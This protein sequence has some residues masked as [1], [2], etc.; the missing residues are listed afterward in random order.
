MGNKL[1]IGVLFGGA[2]SEYEI[3]LLS[4]TSV[5]QNI[6]FNKYDIYK[7]GI[8]RKGEMFLFDGNVD[9][10]MNDTWEENNCTPCTISSNCAYNGIILLNDNI[11]IIRIDCYFPVLHGKNGEDGTIQGLFELTNTPFVGCDMLSSASCMDKDVTKSLL[12]Q[13]NIKNSKWICIHS[14]NYN[15]NSIKQ[16]V[17]TTI[18]YPCFVKPANAGS[19]IGISKV[20]DETSLDAAILLAFKHDKKVLIEENINGIEIECAVLGNENPITSM[21]GEI[22]PCND[23]YDYDAKYLA[24]KTQTFAPARLSDNVTQ[25]IQRIAVDAYKKLGCS[26]FSRIDF[27]YCSNGDIILNEINTIPG[28]TPISMYS[29]LLI[30]SGI[31]YSEIIDRFISLAFDRRCL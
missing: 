18:R 26:G 9:K 16:Q 10:I 2:S 11:V 3:S 31:P 7:I 1:S 20:L 14:H 21:L 15:K 5:F 27:F 23:F 12:T 4:A 13:A 6:D 25:L 28:F 24:G 19:S 30:K 8:N 22:A 17:G 29:Q